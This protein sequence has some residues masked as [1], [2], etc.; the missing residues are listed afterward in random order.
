MKHGL[1]I[2][3]S[4][5]TFIFSGIE[6]YAQDTKNADPSYCLL[7]EF[8]TLNGQP[9]NY[10]ATWVAEL[11]EYPKEAKE[12]GIHGTVKIR[13][14]INRKGVVE[15]VYV[16]QGVHPLLDEEAIRVVR[17]SPKWKPAV[18]DGFA[19][20]VSYTLPVMFNLTTDDY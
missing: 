16:E 13:F 18:K 19:V 8:P 2:I 4:V 12:H 10:F 7:D 17:Q 1:L 5:L 11:V 9:V 14:T 3:I 6:G 20:P 15:N